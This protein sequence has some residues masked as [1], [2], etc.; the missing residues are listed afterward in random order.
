MMHARLPLS[1]F[2][3]YRIPVADLVVKYVFLDPFSLLSSLGCSLSF[4]FFL[5]LFPLVVFPWGLDV[6]VVISVA[7]SVAMLE[8]TISCI[9]QGVFC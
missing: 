4:S 6:V 8:L 2:A 1:Q 9:G 7:G 3:Q 5:F